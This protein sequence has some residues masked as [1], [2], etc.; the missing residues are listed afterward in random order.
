MEIGYD[1]GQDVSE[2]LK[3]KGFQEIRVIKDYADNDRVVSA[4]LPETPQK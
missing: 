1:Q 3:K 4:R 2:L